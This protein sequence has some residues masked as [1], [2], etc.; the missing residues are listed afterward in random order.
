MILAGSWA[1]YAFWRP[2]LTDVWKWTPNFFFGHYIR[3][4]PPTCRPNRSDQNQTDIEVAQLIKI[5]VKQENDL[6]T[7]LDSKV[8]VGCGDGIWTTWPSGYE[9]F[10]R[11]SATP[12]I[13]RVCGHQAYTLAD[14]MPPYFTGFLLLYLLLNILR[15]RWWNRSNIL[16]IF[17]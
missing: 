16:I 14:E 7:L 15:P 9:N 6:R 3:N 12:V 2:F 11:K 13:A 4:T 17:T 5:K 10:Y 1:Q 8:F